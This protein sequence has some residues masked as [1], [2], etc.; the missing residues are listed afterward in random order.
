MPRYPGSFSDGAIETMPKIAVAPPCITA[1]PKPR[2]TQTAMCESGRCQ[3]VQVLD[4]RETG[5]D[6][7]AIDRGINQECDPLRADQADHDQ[8]LDRFLDPRRHVAG[9]SDEFE[10]QPGAQHVDEVAQ[11]RRRRADDDGNDDDAQATSL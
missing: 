8:R 7:E 11:A 1:V 6:R 2:T 4:H 3:V 10:R 5:T 9:V